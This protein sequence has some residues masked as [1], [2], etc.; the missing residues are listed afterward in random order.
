MPQM[1]VTPQKPCSQH[2]ADGPEAMLFEH[3]VLGEFQ[4]SA[5]SVIC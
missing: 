2:V 4:G 1:H 3:G 5:L